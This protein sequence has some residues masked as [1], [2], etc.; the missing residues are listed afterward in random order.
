M[1]VTTWELQ[2]SRYLNQN[3]V[4]ITGTV[5]IAEGGIDTVTLTSSGSNYL[6]VPTISFTPPNKPHH[7]RL[8]LVI[9]HYI[10]HQSQM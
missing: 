1:M 3:K 4:I 5:T 10:I 8:N 2:Q 7:H 9:I 6:S